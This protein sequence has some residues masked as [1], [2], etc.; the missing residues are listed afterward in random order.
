MIMLLFRTA[1]L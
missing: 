1:Y